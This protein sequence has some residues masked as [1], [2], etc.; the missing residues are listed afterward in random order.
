ML[1]QKKSSRARKILLGCV[2][3]G[4]LCFLISFLTS[5]YSAPPTEEELNFKLAYVVYNSKWKAEDHFMK[6]IKAIQK[7]WATKIRKQDSIYYAVV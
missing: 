4:A 6:R 7:T 2:A 1:H 3:F 5:S